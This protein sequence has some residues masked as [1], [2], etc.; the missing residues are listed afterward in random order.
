MKAKI[1]LIVGLALASSL[2]QAQYY[3]QGQHY[4]PNQNMRQSTQLNNGP[5]QVLKGK[6]DALL[7]FLN[8]PQR[9][10]KSQ[11]QAFLLTEIAPAFDF[12]YMTKMAAGRTFSQMDKAK[13]RAMVEALSER[14]LATMIERLNAYQNQ[15][16]RYLAQRT[17]RNG[18]TSTVGIAITGGQSYPA[19]LDFRFYKSPYGWKVYDVLANGQS[20][21]VHYRTQF[22]QMMQPQRL[23]QRQRQMPVQPQM[24]AQ[25]Q[26]Q[27]LPFPDKY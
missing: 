23:R 22:R 13:K 15:R 26:P 20:A 19:R 18:Q 21:V 11:L 2:V 24:P 9:P 17:G 8:Q 16:I 3:W 14:F 7:Q 10:N 25:P 27:P 12:A 1:L 6:M 5:A 4:N